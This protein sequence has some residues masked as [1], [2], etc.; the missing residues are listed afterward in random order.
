MSTVLNY[1]LVHGKRTVK[2]DRNERVI[3][4]RRFG[5]IWS[6]INAYESA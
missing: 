6:E 5:M 1:T 3:S 2:H 4:F